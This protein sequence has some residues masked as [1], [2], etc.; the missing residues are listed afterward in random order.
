MYVIAACPEL[1][2]GRRNDEAISLTR[3]LRFSHDE[4]NEILSVKWRA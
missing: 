3:S 2:S 1:D 4:R